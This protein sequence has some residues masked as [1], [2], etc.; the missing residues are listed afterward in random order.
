[1]KPVKPSDIVRALNRIASD[2]ENTR[3]PNPK[4]LIHNLCVVAAVAQLQSAG[5]GKGHLDQLFD[6]VINFAQENNLNL[7]PKS[8]IYSALEKL[9][10]Q[11][12]GDDI[13][14]EFQA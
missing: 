9:F 12:G 2:L 3:Q 5:G 10:P 7:A 11:G 14:V 4:E 1:M 6:L 8:S 13:D